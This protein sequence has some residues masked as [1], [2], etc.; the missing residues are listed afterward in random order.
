ML[1]PIVEVEKVS[2]SFGDVQ[3]LKDVSLSF[4]PGIVYGLLGPN[5]AGKTTL[6]RILATLLKPT[7]GRARV[8]GI[9]VAAD[10]KSVRR[11]I[12]LGGQFA[13][14]DDYL[15]GRE[16]VEMVGRLY[17]LTA[18]EAHSRTSEILDRIGLMDAADRPVRTYSGGMRRRLDLAASM[19]GRPTMLYLDEPTTGIDPRSR[20]D[21]WELVEELVGFGTTI[22]LTTQYLDEADQLANRIAVID[23]GTLITEGTSEELKD[24]LGGSVVE[25]TVPDPDRTRTVEAI[26]RFGAD[27]VSV[28]ARS[29]RISMPATNG[30]ATLMEAV[31]LLDGAGITPDD[32][33]LR[34][35]TLDDVFLDLT[36]HAAEEPSGDDFNEYPGADADDDAGRG[37]SSRGPGNTKPARRRARSGR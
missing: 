6:I 14:V 32:I 26:S 9:D 36:G 8:A 19:V 23:R 15:T 28:D 4:Q 17:Q 25:L 10:P 13:A 7:S 29:G 24:K 12:G 31:R 1:N 16:N 5:G 22:L 34:R 2:K 3:A 18:A 30:A 21:I 37:R 33:G 11:L 35:P 20:I 27:T